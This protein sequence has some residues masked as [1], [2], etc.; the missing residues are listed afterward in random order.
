M[1]RVHRT[2]LLS[3][4]L[5]TTGAGA[6]PAK[7]PASE[8]PK[9]SPD[10]VP[11]YKIRSIKGFTVVLSAESL[12]HAEDKAYERK[13]LDVLE[14]ELTTLTK[15]LPARAVKI[16][17]TVPVW[18]EWDEQVTVG[19]GRPGSALAV[20]YGGHQLQMLAQGRNR[21]QAKCV[22]I[23][24]LKLLTEEHQPKRDSGRCVLLHEMAHAVHFEL[25]GAKNPLIQGAYKQAMERRLYDP[26][27]Y[28]S[29]NEAE[30]FAELTCAYYGQLHYYPHTRAQLKKHDP[31][32]Y[33]LM[34]KLWGRGGQGG[35]APST[36]TTSG[37]PALQ[38]A[39][40]DLGRTVLGPPVT[41]ENLA[42]RPVLVLLWNAGSP[43]SLSWVPKVSAW[44]T[45][46][47]DFGLLTVG[48]HLTGS[49]KQDVSAAARGR[50][51]RFA[52][53]E[54]RWFSS[55]LIKESKDFPLCLVFDHEGRCVYRG[56][57]FDCERAL[58]AAVG[59][60]LV[61]DSGHTS[62]AT[63]IKALV[64]ALQKGT[65]PSSLLPRLGL[66]ARGNTEAAG[67][68][69]ELL[70]KVTA[71]GR[72]RLEEAEPLVKRNPL[73]A[74]QKL[75]R[76]PA[77]FKG[78]A[79]GSRANALLATLRTNR[80]VREE[81]QARV[82]LR[83]VRRLDTALRARPGSFAPKSEKFRRENLGLLQQLQT[84]VQRMK[85]S[86]PKAPATEEAG[87]VAAKYGLSVP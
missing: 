45:E 53:T 71:V 14:L 8:R 28:A 23:H 61:A 54:A 82:P 67:Q 69:K 26:K 42:G 25:F 27:M 38:L 77:V 86:W 3:L 41:T 5:L 63:P 12:K 31:V 84:A 36:G 78:T 17:R 73:A 62:F 48:I 80:A 51:I 83:T 11:G 76:L 59:R 47:S 18:V 10:A 64:E 35:K 33:Q 1:S 30:F 9:I 40:I 66:L 2:A 37:D 56:S 50:G 16:L 24:R 72:K 68:A 79:V 81:L 22:V 7:S 6:Q 60:A 87:R 58:R 13:P 32:T 43:D 20:Y 75:E 85:K 74:Y 46:L 57:P 34:E 39:Q 44:D 19:N 29:T 70:E 55:G 52:V 15:I 21:L 65:A 49:V 4:L